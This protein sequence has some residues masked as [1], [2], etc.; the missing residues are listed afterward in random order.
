MRIRLITLHPAY[1]TPALAQA[2]R[3]CDKVDR[4]L[5]LPAQSGSDDVLRRMKRGYTTDLYRRRI[6][7]LRAEVPDIEL[8]SDW[9]V[10]FPG[11]TEED[12]AK[13][14]AFVDEI[15]FLVN[16]SSILFEEASIAHFC[17]LFKEEMIR[18]VD[19]IRSDEDIHF[20]PG[21][22]DAVELDDDLLTSLFD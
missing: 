19:H 15:G 21:D 14:E 8:G 1:V 6:D 17:Q 7:I 3:D 4:F 10:G 22:F 12:F 11:E 9:I 5:P 16:Y 13:T 20:T 18:L 2:I